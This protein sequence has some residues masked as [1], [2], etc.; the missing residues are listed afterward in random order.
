VKVLLIFSIL[1]SLSNSSYA[2]VFKV[3]LH[4]SI[5]STTLTG[6]DNSDTDGK[7]VS[8]SNLF[9]GLNLAYGITKRLHFL[10]DYTTG[11]ISYDNTKSILNGDSNFQVSKLAT[12]VKFIAFPRVAFRAYFNSDDDLAFKVDETNQASV[13][14]ENLNYLSVFYDQI[15]F[16][17]GAMYSG[18]KLGYDIST[19]GT[20]TTDRTGSTIGLF[21][22]IHGLSVD[23]EIR[24][25]T[26]SNSSLDFEENDTALKL[27]Y[28][29]SF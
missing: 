3:G 5:Y 13:Y 19:S 27:Q 24:S 29:F 12:G 9:Y 28:L 26:K 25:I 21:G 23:Y 11:T 17:G 18:F 20:D 22:V 10:L 15:V 1:I 7:L 8:N 2:Q 16:M 4:T 6:S 14:S